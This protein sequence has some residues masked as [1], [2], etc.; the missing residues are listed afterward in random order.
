M[1][2]PSSE[3]KEETQG[4]C[5]GVGIYCSLPCKWI[6]PFLTDPKMKLFDKKEVVWKMLGIM[7]FCW[8]F[9]GTNEKHSLQ[10]NKAFKNLQKAFLG[11]CWEEILKNSVFYVILWDLKWVQFFLSHMNYWDLFEKVMLWTFK[12]LSEKDG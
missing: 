6:C 7:S 9:F 10:L 3:E 2:I 1:A 12:T 5:N 4:T 8:S 11:Q